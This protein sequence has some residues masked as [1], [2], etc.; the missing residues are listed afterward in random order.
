MLAITFQIVITL[1]LGGADGVD[2]EIGFYQATMP[3]FDEEPMFRG[4]ILLTLSLGI[5]SNRFNVFGA[6]LNIA[7]LVFAL[8][9]ASVH[10]VSV[11]TVK[12]TLLL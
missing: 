4:I 5:V 7:G 3:G 11:A 2:T 9:F 10:G 6:Q 12:F 8:L 1:A